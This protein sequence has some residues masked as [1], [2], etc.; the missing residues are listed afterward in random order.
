M[1]L[2]IMEMIVTTQILKIFA[3]EG[4]V[5][6]LELRFF[7][8]SKRKKVKFFKLNFFFSTDYKKFIRA[9]NNHQI[10]LKPKYDVDELLKRLWFTSDDFLKKIRWPDRNVMKFHEKI[11]RQSKSFQKVIR[12]EPETL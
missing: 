10:V 4:A 11:M 3:V 2:L 8:S 9:T 12:S 7:F 5:A 6:R 1:S